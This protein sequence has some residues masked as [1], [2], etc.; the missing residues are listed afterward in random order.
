MESE[1]RRAHLGCYNLKND[2]KYVVVRTEKNQGDICLKLCCPKEFNFKKN[3]VCHVLKK[4]GDRNR[5]SHLRNY[6]SK[7]DKV[8]EA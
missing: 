2:A 3:D 1:A 8:L 4:S 6:A 5:M 7:E